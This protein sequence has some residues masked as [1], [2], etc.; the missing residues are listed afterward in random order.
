MECAAYVWRWFVKK[1]QM[2]MKFFFAIHLKI[3]KICWK[4]CTV[5]K[6]HLTGDITFMR[7]HCAMINFFIILIKI[8]A[9]YYSSR[10]SLFRCIQ[11]AITKV[12]TINLKSSIPPFCALIT[13]LTRDGK[14]IAFNKKNLKRFGIT[15]KFI[16]GDNYIVNEVIKSPSLA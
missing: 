8:L 14:F 1:R 5:M 2:M 9:W 15:V 7:K 13:K 11:V 12:K 4:N 3:N 16:E 6:S 10:R